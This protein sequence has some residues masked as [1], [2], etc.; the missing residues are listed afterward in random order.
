MFSR[1]VRKNFASVS[2]Y[3]FVI[4]VIRSLRHYIQEKPDP[5]TYS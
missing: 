4:S 3:I 5:I 1:L 2:H